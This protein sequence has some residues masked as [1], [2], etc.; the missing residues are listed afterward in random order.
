MLRGITLAE[1]EETLNPLRKK[2]GR[3]A[4]RF[5]GTWYAMGEK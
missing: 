5:E 1:A 4:C 3:S 2:E